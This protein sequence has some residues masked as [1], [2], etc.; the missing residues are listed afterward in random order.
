VKYKKPLAGEGP[1]AQGVMDDEVTIFIFY[2]NK[3]KHK[4]SLYKNI[5]DTVFCLLGKT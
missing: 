1:T 5:Y 2:H 4:S 3:Y